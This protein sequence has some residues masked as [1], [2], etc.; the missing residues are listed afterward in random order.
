MK[1]IQIDID[2]ADEDT[3]TCEIT[4]EALEAASGARMGGQPTLLHT[5]CFGCPLVEVA[6]SGS[7]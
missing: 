3:V 1:D 4:D 6:G 7:E 2:R 5:Y